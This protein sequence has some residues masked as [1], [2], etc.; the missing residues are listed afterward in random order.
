M[1]RHLD[2]IE[3]FRSTENKI[4]KYEKRL[5]ERRERRRKRNIKRHERKAEQAME[6]FSHHVTRI[7]KKM[8]YLSGIEAFI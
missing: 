6:E 8:G 3:D 4:G 2:I 5:L 7:V 1:H